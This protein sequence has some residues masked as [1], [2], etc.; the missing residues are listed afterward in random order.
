MTNKEKVGNEW[1]TPPDVMERARVAL[2]DYVYL[3]PCGAP[4]GT[5]SHVNSALTYR[6][7]QNGLEMTWSCQR[8]WLNPPFSPVKPWLKRLAD[9][10]RSGQVRA[11]LALVSDRALVGEGGNTILKAAKALIVPAKRIRFVRP[12]TGEL[13]LSPSFGAVLV[14]GGDDLDPLRI[15]WAFEDDGWATVFWTATR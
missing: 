3:D 8:M 4:S 9:G 6:L 11:G 2:G 12:D 13:E 14:A 1:R 7:P 5:P 10:W 15:R